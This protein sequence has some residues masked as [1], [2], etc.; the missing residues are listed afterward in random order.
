MHWLVAWTRGPHCNIQLQ[1]SFFKSKDSFT[2]QILD[3]ARPLQG[4]LLYTLHR[5]KV[6]FNLSICPGDPGSR[7]LT[8]GFF[9]ASS[10]QE[11]HQF[12]KKLPRVTYPNLGSPGKINEENVTLS[13]WRVY[14]S[15]SCL[16]NFVHT[17]KL[18]RSGGTHFPFFTQSVTISEIMSYMRYFK[19]D[20]KLVQWS[21]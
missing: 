3:C 12:K 10:P 9:F 13:W 19:I 4:R 21:L 11:H 15:Y 14:M 5:K 17:R 18:Q 2:S 20:F 6:T 16:A 1:T 8:P 7:T